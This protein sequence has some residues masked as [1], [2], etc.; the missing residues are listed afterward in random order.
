MTQPQ[1]SIAYFSMEMALD[2]RF[3]TYS[4]GLGMLAGDTLR[5]AADMQ[6]PMVGITLLHRLGYFSQT[7]DPTGWQQES[8]ERWP[9]S[10]NLEAVQSRISVLVGGSQV[11]VRAWKYRVEGQ[12]GFVVPVYLL[13]TSASENTEWERT[14]TDHLYG[15][16]ERYRLAQEIVLGIG[17]IKILRALG[18]DRLA[19]YHMNEGHA[20]LLALE[21]LRE[22]ALRAGRRMFTHNDVA[23]VKSQCVFTTH[24]P[25]AAG[26][27]QFPLKLVQQLLGPPE[28][29]EMKE[30]FCCEG[31]MN[32]TYLALNLSHYVNGVP[33]ATVKSPGKSS[34]RET[35][36]TIIKST[37]SQTACTCPLGRHPRS[38]ICL[39]TSFQAGEKTIRACAT[40]FASMAMGCGKPMPLQR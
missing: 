32:M 25:V 15:G 36:I 24:T 29:F 9:Y 17:G 31:V 4:G 10:E 22:T 20:S 33:S 40:P 39:T 1:C 18:Y 35:R 26:H 23:E 6:V 5:A 8:N 14:L 27:D 19:R 7:I 37:R 38:L 3:P 21:L 30:V 16:D 12:G 28:L 2:L 34:R 11:A 13:D